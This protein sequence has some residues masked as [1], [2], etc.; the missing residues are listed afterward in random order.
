[1]KPTIEV[2]YELL[3]YDIFTGKLYWHNRDI[4]W[5]KNKISQKRWNTRFAGK[6]AFNTDSRG[7]RVGRLFKKNY[8]AHHVIWCMTV[9]YWPK[10]L[11]HIDGNPSN[12]TLGNLR[13]VDQK[14][15]RKNCK[16]P[17]NNTSGVQGVS[18]N[19]INKNWTAQIKINRVKHHLGSFYSKDDAIKAR[20]EAEIKYNFHPNHGRT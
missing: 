7:Y 5:F 4:K 14:E 18:W 16:I 1:M 17:S 3:N 6:E 19:T 2:L 8:F 11:D 10:Q 9:G 12:N 20:K 15:N 13:E